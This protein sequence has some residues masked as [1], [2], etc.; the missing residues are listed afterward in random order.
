MDELLSKS[1][2]TLALCGVVSLVFGILAAF[3]LE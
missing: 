2:R 3:G 1:W